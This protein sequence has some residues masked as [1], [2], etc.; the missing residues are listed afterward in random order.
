MPP[1]AEARSRFLA[2]IEKAAKYAKQHPPGVLRE[3]PGRE[4]SLRWETLPVEI[5]LSILCRCRL[6]DIQG[7][8]LVCRSLHNLIDRNEHA[9]SRD[10]LRIRRHGSLPSQQGPRA[11]HTRAPQDD[12]ILLSDLFPPSEGPYN[13]KDAYTFR[14]LAGLQRRQD[15]CSKLAY[16]LADRVL[17][18]YIQSDP[19]IK[20]SFASKR[21]RQACHERG[22]TLLQFK[23]T[24]IMFYVLYFFETYSKVRSN[25]LIR[26]HGRRGQPR[27]FH[28]ADEHTF[29][30]YILRGPI[31]K[32][33]N[34]LL[35]THHVFSLLAR[36]LLNAVATD[37]PFH[38]NGEAF[39][40]ML[41][42]IGLE[43]IVEFF[44][45]EKGGGYNQRALRKTFMRNMQRDWDAFMKREAVYGDIEHHPMPLDYI[46]I[47]PAME[48][49]RDRGCI[50]H[51]SQD[52]VIVWEGAKIYL[53]CQH[54]RG[55][56][57]G[58]PAATGL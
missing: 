23:L 50:P 54:C 37:Y 32:D 13:P 47:A 52:W 42:T 22:V 6:Q 56:D 29:Q 27:T 15:T 9:I 46:W 20:T 19:E 16:Y 35:S 7:L 51:R 58:W 24:P 53:D 30:A 49:L 11:V 31:F 38:S 45:A 44:A 48:T 39:A 2:A 25:E 36:Y 17:D 5:Q 34:V 18:G 26:P 33:T 43:R 3:P 12:V 40:S 21:D 28:I 8:R 14:Y 10:Y 55:M 1:F 57:D 4:A 41:L